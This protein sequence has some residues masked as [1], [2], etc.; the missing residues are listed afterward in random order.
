M[1]YQIY[2]TC[3]DRLTKELRRELQADKRQARQLLGR[4]LKKVDHD[5]LCDLAVGL[6]FGGMAS[7]R[8]PD[9]RLLP[10]NAAVLLEEWQYRRD[11]RH[12]CFPLPG[13]LESLYDS[14]ME[15]DLEAF[16]VPWRVFSLAVPQGEV[17]GG[18]ALPPALVVCCT[19]E[20]K[21]A[22]VVR[23][24]KAVK[25]D[26]SLV[27]EAELGARSLFLTYSAGD[28]LVRCS[29]PLRLLPIILQNPTGEDR[30][31]EFLHA[32]IGDYHGVP[33][34]QPL[35]SE[36]YRIQYRLVKSIAHLA[37]YMQAFPE[38][39]KTGYP[40]QFVD[41][42]SSGYRGGTPYTVGGRHFHAERGS[43]IGHWRRKHFRSYPV[44]R[45]GTRKAGLVEVRG[46]WVNPDSPHTVV[47]VGE[48]SQ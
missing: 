22:L 9:N 8:P 26:I 34:V 36:E 41:N 43:P 3:T 2:R 16:A 35:S 40:E 39:V 28:Q 38:S 44:K 48:Q 29:L 6:Q 10:L 47:A 45:D 24:N 23:F 27:T 42:G 4:P 13:L 12:V 20:E 5:E 11:A 31:G 30:E 21:E 1:H 7:Q 15:V 32:L 14:R 17:V 33:D 25:T 19:R 46:T 37:V 18:L